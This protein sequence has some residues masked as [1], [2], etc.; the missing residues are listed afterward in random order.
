MKLRDATPADAARL[1]ELLTKLI[2]DEAQYDSN[3]N[4]SYVVTDNYL[5][6]IGLEGHK[7]LLIEDEGEIVAF[8]YGFLYELPGMLANAVL[9]SSM[10]CMLRRHTAGKAVPHSSF[11]HSKPLPQKAGLA[12]S[13]SRFYHTMKLPYVFTKSSLSKKRKST[14]RW[15]YGST[16]SAVLLFIQMLAHHPRSCY[17]G[18]KVKADY[19]F[20]GN[21][22]ANQKCAAWRRK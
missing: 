16:D 2:H 12:A 17:T 20:G 7:L 19:V 22:G 13:S 8:L 10:H 6:R 14:W 1:D 4:G 11:L 3:L 9:R 21:N 15:I 18:S 5:D